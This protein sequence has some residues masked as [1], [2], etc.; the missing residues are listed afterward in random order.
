MQV[1]PKRCGHT[2]GKQVVDRVEAYDRIRAA[3]EARREMKDQDI[4]IL[5][6][7]DAR[8]I[9]LD[10]AIERCRMFMELG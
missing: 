4:V 3:V 10:E 8:I 6:R 5:A 7:T 9:S 2:S 1:S